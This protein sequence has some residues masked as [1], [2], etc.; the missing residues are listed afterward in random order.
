M[1]TITQFLSSLVSEVFSAFSSGEAIVALSAL[2][3]VQVADPKIRDLVDRIALPTEEKTG[4][5]IGRVYIPP[6]QEF[7]SLGNTITGV[8]APPVT[9]D[10][11][12]TFRL[13]VHIADTKAAIEV[14]RNLY[15]VVSPSTKTRG[16]IARGRISG[17]TYLRRISIIS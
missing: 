8:S 12:P 15:Y 11:P 10:H 2:I 14:G 9:I 4:S 1:D 17:K 16:E 13:I 3:L 5:V 7:I 6:R